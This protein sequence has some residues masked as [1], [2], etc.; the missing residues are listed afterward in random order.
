MPAPPVARRATCGAR[1]SAR[2]LLWWP[3][4]RSSRALGLPAFL[5]QEGDHPEATGTFREIARLT[6]GAHCRDTRLG[7]FRRPTLDR[8]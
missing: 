8:P 3:C 6:K 1:R 7:L 2:A 5:F 4:R